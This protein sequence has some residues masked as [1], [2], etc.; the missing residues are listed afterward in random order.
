MSE[1][2]KF[3][4][5]NSRRKRFLWTHQESD[6]APHA[7]VGLVGD[8]KKFT[9]ALCLQSLIFLSRATSRFH[10]SQQWW[11][12]EATFKR[13]VQIELACE[14]DGDGEPDDRADVVSVSL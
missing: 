6:L 12:I 9:Q 3:L 1:P 8:A 5:L 10:V 13:L 2:C 4:S 7:V 11:R 14:P